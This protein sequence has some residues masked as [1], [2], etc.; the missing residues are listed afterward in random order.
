MY[1]LQLLTVKKIQMFKHV[2]TEEISSTLRS[3]EQQS[4]KGD[5][6]VDVNKLAFSMVGNI[7]TRMLFSKQAFGSEVSTFKDMFLEMNVLF[8]VPLIGDVIPC[9]RWLDVPGYKKRMDNL[10]QRL[11]A[12]L[13]DIL[14]ERMRNKREEGGEVSAL[15]DVLDVLIDTYKGDDKDSKDWIKSGMLEMLGAGVDTSSTTIEWAMTELLRNPSSMTKLQQ[16]M[17]SVI[18]PLASSVQEEDIPKLEYLQAVV[19]ETL[20]L[21]PPFPLM[22]R[23]MTKSK[24][25][26]QG[27][28]EYMLPEKTRLIVNLWAMGR[29][30]SVW[31]EA[32]NEFK[33]ERFIKSSIDVR[34]HD[35]ELIP[36]GSGKRVCP[37]M[38]L[39]L[40]IVP[41]VVANLVYNFHW[42]LPQG[43]T[44]LSID[45]SEA[46]AIGGPKSIPL[47]AC[48]TPSSC[49]TCIVEAAY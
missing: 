38:N 27:V 14:E 48:A 15:A 44:P 1:T 10:A 26:K 7:L 21:H 33:P 6:V 22:L 30:A 4:N 41:L 40:C 11:D 24:K 9:L 8:G 37:G 39:A 31:G 20:R 45:M 23:Q 49:R 46:Q 42:R 16:E 19:K 47:M 29:D 12:F 34:G 32:C 25:G 3:L 5:H 18:G 2:R 43:V 17:D 28:G 13:E 36:F 35:F